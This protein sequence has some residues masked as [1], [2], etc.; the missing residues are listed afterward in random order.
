MSWTH[1]TG[2]FRQ[3]SV[4]TRSGMPIVNALRL[5][6]DTA[7]SDYRK[8]A[9]AWAVGCSQ[10]KDL[11]SQMAASGESPFIVAL[12]KAGETTGRLPELCS[13]ISD[14]FS[15][16]VALRGLAIGKLIYPVCLL[17][18]ALVVPA[19]PKVF[20]EGS[21]WLLLAGPAILWAIVIGLVVAGKI[22]HQA[23]V[24][25]RLAVMPGPRFLFLPFLT[26]NTCLVLA[27]A[28]A[29][30]M[31]VRDALELAAGACGNRVFAANLN[32]AAADVER[33]ALPNLTTA[34]RQAGLPERLCDL[35][36]SGEQ[37]G[38]LEVVLDQAAVAARE[39]FQ[40][41]IT[42][43]TKVFTSMI[44]GAVVIYVGWT[45]VSMYTGIMNSGIEAAGGD[46]YG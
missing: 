45:V 44:Y 20:G 4:L 39:S 19:I 8:R 33:G 18:M 43:S 27:A 2:F 14:H 5:A 10:G 25:A 41:R 9:D 46:P 23:G 36:S 11:A 13:R 28:M 7:G 37:S 3:L 15:Q 17:H 22:W 6:G 26:C 16:L 29:A 30:G 31:K 42:W 40:T 24:L 12:V 32:Q 1:S 34:L 35:I 38:T 21:P